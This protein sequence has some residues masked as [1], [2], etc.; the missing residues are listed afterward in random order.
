ME[1]AF[2]SSS[3][4][5]FELEKM[6]PNLTS[7]ILSVFYRY[8]QQFISSMLVG[9]NIVLVV[10]GLQMAKLLTPLFFFTNNQFVITLLQSIIATIIVLFTGEF[11][12]KTLFRINPN[13]W[14]RTF[15]WLVFLFYIVLYPIAVFTTWLSKNFLKLFKMN[16]DLDDNNNM[17]SRIDLSYLVQES[18]DTKNPEEDLDAEVKIFQ[19]ALDFS[20]IKLRDCSVPRT[21][22]VALDYNT[23]LETLKQTFIETGFSKIPIYKENIDNI[24]GYI[25]SSEMFEHPD[26]WK[27]HIR[28]IPIVPENMTAHKLMK[29]FMQQKKSIAV[30]VDEHGGTEGMV[31]LE[32][33]IE[34]IFGEIEDEHDVK[35][36]TA[37]QLSENEYLLSGRMEVEQ[38]NEKFGIGIPESDEYDTMAGFILHHH[39]HFPKANE[40]IQ[41]EDFKFKCIKVANNRIELLRLILGE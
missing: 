25:H 29:L 7:S 22:I 6:R 37:E 34:E 23:S 16:T 4:L 19:N 21:E 17:F 13:W 33:I 14:L 8:P 39:Q 35:E 18:F 36:Y 12:P 31:T 38:V 40:I 28:Q 10:Y 32:D 1:I 5:R 11:L 26:E 30:V 15:S 9:N 27:K 2:V 20:K 3:K 24:I 41:I